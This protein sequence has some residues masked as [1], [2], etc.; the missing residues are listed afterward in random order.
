MQQ[1]L[2]KGSNNALTQ[3]QRLNRKSINY[4]PKDEYQNHIKFIESIDHSLW[5]QLN[6]D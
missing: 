4:L 3:N 2:S 6:K 5:E 1:G